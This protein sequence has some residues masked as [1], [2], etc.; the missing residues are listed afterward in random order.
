MYKPDKH[1][2]ENFF[3]QIITDNIKKLGVNAVRVMSL[4]LRKSGYVEK[5]DLID[6]LVEEYIS[7]MIS[8]S[9]ENGVTNS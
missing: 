9:S 5:A 6:F 8:G 3:R 4:D 7:H 1:S 2:I